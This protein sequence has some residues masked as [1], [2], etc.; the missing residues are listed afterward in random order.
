M[1]Y[2][3]DVEIATA[4]AN[5]IRGVKGGLTFKVQIPSNVL[6]IVK[7]GEFLSSLTTKFLVDLIIE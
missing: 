3:V 2:L 5:P 7:I 4:M 1:V 6:N